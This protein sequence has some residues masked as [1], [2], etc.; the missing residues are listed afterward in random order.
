[1]GFLCCVAQDA[2]KYGRHPQYS[3]Y[4]FPMMPTQMEILLR[5]GL[6]TS[7]LDPCVAPSTT[8]PFY[9]RGNRGTEVGSMDHPPCTWLVMSEG[10]GEGGLE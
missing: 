5:V 8:H 6:I 4:L 1:M 3:Q 2:P 7:A 10:M 9:G